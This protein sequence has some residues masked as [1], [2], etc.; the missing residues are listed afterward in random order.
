MLVILKSDADGEDGPY[1]IGAVELSE[2]HDLAD[3]AA[4][5]RELVADMQ[6]ADDYEDNHVLEELD[7]RGYTLAD[8]PPEILV[9]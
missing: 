8:P 9:R 2:H 3:F 5:V 4:E 6:D 1:T 7:K